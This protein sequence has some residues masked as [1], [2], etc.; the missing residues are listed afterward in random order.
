MSEIDRVLKQS[1]VNFTCTTN[2][3]KHLSVEILK[4][5]I[6]RNH[7]VHHNLSSVSKHHLAKRFIVYRICSVLF[8]GQ[9]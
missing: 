1:Y 9:N 3:Y 7:R 4:V 8:T 2:A 5:Y 6:A